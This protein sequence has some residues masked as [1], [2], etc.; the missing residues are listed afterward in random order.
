MHALRFNIEETFQISSRGT[1]V[2]IREATDFPVGMA[3]HATIFSPDGSQSTVQ[4]FKEYLLRHNPHAVEKEAYLLQGIE[5][6][7]IREGSRIE[8]EAI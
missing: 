5:K 1:V 6:D 2:T 3:L 7:Q 4:A 8:F